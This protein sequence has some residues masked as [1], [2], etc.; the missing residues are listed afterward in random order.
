[1]VVADDSPFVRRLLREYLDAEPDMRVVGEARDGRAAV[2]AA[3]DIR[4]DAMTLDLVMPELDGLSALSRI[5]TAHP[6]P[7]VLI[8]GAGADGA[9]LTRK[10]LDLG[11]V[12]FILKYAPMRV[13]SAEA[14][15]RE[16]V[17]TV[18]AAARVKVIRSIPSMARAVATASVGP[19]QKGPTAAAPPLRRARPPRLVVV[20]ASTGGPLAIKAMLAGL[21][22]RLDFPM[23]IVQ[24][25]PA[26]FTAILAG[27]LDRIFPFTVREA[28]DGDGLTPGRVLIAPGDRH[29][30][31]R[32]DGAVRLSD[33]DP[34][35]GHRPAI[36]VAF[37]SAAH[38]LGSAVAGVLL[39]GMGEDGVAGM[40]AIAE[41]RGATMVQDPATCVVDTMPAAAIERGAAGLIA[42][43]D[44][45]GRRLANRGCE[46]ET[47]FAFPYRLGP[48]RG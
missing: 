39:S 45:I 34:V 3:A 48:L 28:A 22:G 16:I 18:R 46:D 30:L 12:D 2:A 5:M 25:M 6:V 38:V 11:A 23:V 13:V 27:Q 36:D 9:R 7:V 1:M 21:G 20:G 17:S 15:R 42:A 33:A 8:S 40:A 19:G 4:P 41:K 37:Q 32:P 43:P 26:G 10:G 31:I 24:H 47:V 14:L 44:A 35:R 29:L